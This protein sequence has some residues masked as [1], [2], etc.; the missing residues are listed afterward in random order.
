M[1]CEPCFNV[2]SQTPHIYTT[3]NVIK[4]YEKYS[5]N[6]EPI[7]KGKYSIILESSGTS[8]EL[9]KFEKIIDHKNNKILFET[10][11]NSSRCLLVKGEKCKIILAVDI[12]T[13]HF[14]R[15][16]Y[17]INCSKNKSNI[18]FEGCWCLVLC[19]ECLYKDKE[20]T[21]FINSCPS[22]KTAIGLPIKIDLP[23]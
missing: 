10:P 14:G 22:C 4:F 5:F 9:D 13:N 2:L 15:K 23:L 12:Y 8:F 17:C 16:D 3:D 19:D 11:E 18:F 20:K 21:M 1:K 7:I 6:N